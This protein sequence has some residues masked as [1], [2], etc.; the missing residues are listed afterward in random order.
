MLA[1]YIE[2]IEFAP[3]YVRLCYGVLYG[4]CMEVYTVSKHSA[5]GTI[6]YCRGKEVLLSAA[7][8]EGTQKLGLA[9]L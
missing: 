5:S 1:H 2:L 6:H 7:I 9:K 4:V 8:E 3:G